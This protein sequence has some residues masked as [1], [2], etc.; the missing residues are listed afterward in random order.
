MKIVILN[1]GCS[2]LLSVK[3]AI[4]RLGY[5]VK[6]SCDKKQIYNSD[7][8]IFPGV[9]SIASVM[10]QLNRK[11]LFNVIKKIQQPFLGICLGMQALSMFSEESGG[12]NALN[13]IPENVLLLK[14]NRLVLPHSGWNKVNFSIDNPLFKNITNGDY[15]YFLHS[16]AMPLNDY[17]I[18]SS[19]YGINFSSA[20]QKD[21]FFGVQFHPEKSGIAGQK[22]LKNFLCI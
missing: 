20:I 8:V 9:G 11:F 3:L 10:Y 19:V 18:A 4:H 15:F 2:N 1:T 6:I 17:T 21:N 12:V 16:Y 5:D 14:D 7:K 13:I 22:I